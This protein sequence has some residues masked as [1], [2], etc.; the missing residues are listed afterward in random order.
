M[1]EQLAENR[2]LTRQRRDSAPL[3]LQGLTVA[4]IAASPD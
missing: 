2:K 3:R 1:Q 4:D